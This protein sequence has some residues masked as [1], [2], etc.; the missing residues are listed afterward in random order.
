MKSF[1]IVVTATAG[2][3]HINA[4]AGSMRQL[5]QRGHR[6][7]FMIEEGFRGKLSPLGFEEFIYKTAKASES[8][9]NAGD[10]FAAD[11]MQSKVFGPETPWEKLVNVVNYIDGPGRIR[12]IREMDIGMKEAI[13]TFKPD[14]ICNDGNA[15]LPSIH[16]SGIPWVRIISSAPLFYMMDDSIPPG[17]SGLPSDSDQNEWKVWNNIRHKLIYGKT[18]NDFIESWG[19]ERFPNDLR[20]PN[21]EQ[22]TVYAYPELIN[23]EPI[24]NWDEVFN[25][26]VEKVPELNSL[27][28]DEFL[29]SNLNGK[30]SGKLIYVSMGSL[31]SIDLSLMKRLVD[32]LSKTKHKYI[33]S[34]GPRFAEYELAENMFGKRFLPQTS[35]VPHVDL[36]ITHGGNN[37]V[38]EVFAEGKPMIVLPNFVDQFDNAQR[39]HE[40]GFGIRLNPYEF[41]HKELS[42]A[43]DKLLYNEM[44]HRQLQEASNEIRANDRH[45]QLAKLIEQKIMSHNNIC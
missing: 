40:T 41:S 44:L 13:E 9:G 6:I 16:Y 27:V 28:P 34:K 10:T 19:Y 12:D 36:V 35:I 39:L 17:A 11:L 45:L 43:I 7:I 38:T 32:A 37:T 24:Q 14:L 23:Y 2:W 1:T 18:L 8:K 3:G 33:F 20:S 25:K 4:V 30:F 29:N 5:L 21:S 31:S 15:C 42:D 22:I 26:N